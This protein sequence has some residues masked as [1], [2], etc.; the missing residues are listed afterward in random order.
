M[1]RTVLSTLKIT[2]TVTENNLFF[3][4]AMNSEGPYSG[5]T[6]VNGTIPNPLDVVLVL[7][8]N[9]FPLDYILYTA[10]VIQLL[11]IY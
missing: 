3:V 6:L 10:L 4:K 11:L 7:T 5:Y 1:N 2:P 9:I 8:Q